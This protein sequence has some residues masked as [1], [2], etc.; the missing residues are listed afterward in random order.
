VPVTSTPQPPVACISA[1]VQSAPA[2]DS[3]LA[4]E[5][6]VHATVCSTVAKVGGPIA[7]ALTE[8]M[9]VAPAPGARIEDH[10]VE[11]GAAW[12]ITDS[13]LAGSTTLVPTH[14]G[15]ERVLSVVPSVGN[16]SAAEEEEE[17]DASTCDADSSVFTTDTAHVGSGPTPTSGT[18]DT[19]GAMDDQIAG[20]VRATA[21][22]PAFGPTVVADAVVPAGDGEAAPQSESRAVG[23]TSPAVDTTSAPD[24]SPVTAST[25]ADTAAF[26]M[27][28][29]PTRTV[30]DPAATTD[31]T[32]EEHHDLVSPPLPVT[33]PVYSAGGTSPPSDRTKTTTASA[34][35]TP[36]ATSHAS[37][38]VHVLSDFS[39][40]N[41][42]DIDVLQSQHAASVVHTQSA[43]FKHHAADLGDAYESD[44]DSVASPDTAAS[45]NFLHQPGDPVGSGDDDD[46]NPAENAE[47][48]TVR[49]GEQEIPEQH[50]GE[51]KLV[52]TVPGSS[53]AEHAKASGGTEDALPVERLGS[54][55][56]SGDSCGW[57]NDRNTPIAA[58]RPR[59]DWNRSAPAITGEP[60]SSVVPHMEP[61]VGE[62]A[63]HRG[64]T[65]DTKDASTVADTSRGTATVG[66]NPDRRPPSTPLAVP[67]SGIA[68][69]EPAALSST[70]TELTHVSTPAHTATEFD[71]PATVNHAASQHQVGHPVGDAAGDALLNASDFGDYGAENMDEE[72][73]EED[74][75][76]E[77]PTQQSGEDAAVSNVPDNEAAADGESVGTERASSLDDATEAT[78]PADH[79]RSD[80]YADG[81]PGSAVA[82]GTSALTQ[83]PDRTAHGQQV[84][85]MLQGLDLAVLVEGTVADD[86]LL[87][88][89]GGD[90]FGYLMEDG[91]SYYEDTALQPTTIEGQHDAA[92]EEV[93]SN[94]AN[95]VL[96]CAYV[97]VYES[98]L[99]RGWLETVGALCAM[100]F[101]IALPAVFQRFLVDVLMVLTL[102]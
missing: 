3:D 5:L 38:S 50:S 15:A 46:A 41:L 99:P 64:D 51:E 59:K 60:G 91:G 49:A 102:L 26:S 23:A 90:D 2:S 18:A 24:P 8:E 7:P 28:S 58:L 78:F 93:T 47:N 11:A 92:G 54:P 33:A 56:Y 88:T 74:G 35:T 71:V 79:P 1:A 52:W 86:S 12:E 19:A 72:E 25:S 97:Y 14:G 81:A 32:A 27:R 67:L 69:S 98:R 39:Y 21:Q 63:A 83:A 62:S 6:V 84:A 30:F 66:D 48:P 10:T 36:V 65:G 76:G 29:V 77:T 82:T 16:E 94:L 101:A 37:A 20:V 13:S 43:Q 22:I 31:P 4:P 80:T 17:H 53:M 45:A 89:G 42:P 9:T 85:Q 55:T 70:H 68:G 100:L 95:Q 61:S 75:E 96:L 44:W 40:S 34:T 57:F 73:G 87:Y